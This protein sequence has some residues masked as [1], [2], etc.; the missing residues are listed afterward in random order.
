[1]ILAPAQ[2]IPHGRPYRYHPN[3][4]TSLDSSLDDLSNS[5]YGHSSS[6]HSLPALPLDPSRKRSRSPTIFVLI[7][8]P[9]PRAL[10][11]AHADLLPPPKRIKS[12]DSAMN[13]E[14][15]LDESSDSSVPRETSLRDD[16]IVRGSDEPHSKPDIDLEIQAKINKCIAYADAFKAEGIDAK[17]M[18]ETVAREEVEMRTRGPVE[19]RVKKVTHPTVPDDILKPAQEEGAIEGQQSVVLSKRISELERD[20]TRLKGTLDVVSQRVSRLQRRE[21]REMEI[22]EM[23]IEDETSIEMVMGTEE[24][25]AITLEEFSVDLLA[26]EDGDSVPRNDLTAYNRRF[27]ELVLFCTRMVSD[28]EDKVERFIGGLLD[29][30]YENVI[31]AEPTRLQDA[32]RIANNLMDQKLKGYARSAKNKRR[33]DN[34]PRDNRGRKCYA[35]M[36]FD[37]G[38]D[39]S[40]VS[41]TFSA[42]LDVAPSTLD[43]SY[44]VELADGRISETN[45]ILRGCM[46][47][48]LGHPFDIDLMPIEF[49][50]FNVAI[51]MD[52]LAKYHVVIVCE[53]KI[54]CIP[55][56]DK[57]LIIRERM[58]SLSKKA[59][60]KSEEKRLE[61]VLIVQQF[62]EV[63]SEDLPGLPPA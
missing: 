31:A 24:E 14:D 50:S 11:L 43:T 52:W 58:T 27:Q 40:F 54:I 37:S 63:F 18:V 47:G 56:E 48:L 44:E 23:E 4:P 53:K 59:D 29:N 5:L 55:Y 39:R 13:L 38:A 62:S 8:S 20:N 9:I 1:M 57:V 46:L 28:E 33:F 34:N 61:D 10:S 32:I 17:V 51:S 7:S 12:F 45:V 30:I 3:G 60:D 21:L 49:G 22:K 42:L 35:S 25:M 26:Q 16:V 19:V 36:L 41:S 15:C 2:P 6:D